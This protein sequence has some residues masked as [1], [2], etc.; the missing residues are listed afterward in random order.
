[1]T[2]YRT[3][4]LVYDYLPLMLFPLYVSIDRLDRR[5]VEASRDLGLGR[6]RTFRRVTL[7]L[8]APG[9]LAGSVLAWSRALGEF[10]A[11]I[12]FAGNSPGRTE[13]MPIA[14]YLALRGGNTE[15]A[16]VLSLLMLAVSVLVLTLLRDRWLRGPQL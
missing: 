10:G 1:M 5:L 16:V 12:T 13:T 15:A 9:I 7:P 3:V 2:M 6:V 8:V 11:T 14:V 4:G